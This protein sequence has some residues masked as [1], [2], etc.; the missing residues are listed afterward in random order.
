M[1]AI[2]SDED[3]IQLEVDGMKLGETAADLQPVHDHHRDACLQVEFPAHGK[4]APGKK[5][6]AYDEIRHQRAQFGAWFALVIVGQAIQA[7]LLNER[8]QRYSGFRCDFQIMGGK[9]FRQGIALGS[10]VSKKSRIL[11]FQRSICS[12]AQVR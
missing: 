10:G 8:L 4:S 7:F 1:G 11:S 2:V 9:F 5:R 3:A 12:L 6:V